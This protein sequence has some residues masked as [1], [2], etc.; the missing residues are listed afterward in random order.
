MAIPKPTKSSR[1]PRL[2]SGDHLTASEFLERYDEMPG[3]EKAVFIDGVV[4]VPS[5]AR[6]DLHGVQHKA[7]GT[8]WVYTGRT[9]PESRPAIVQR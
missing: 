8:G 9:R 7:L 3:L 2:E 4:Y 6:W 1:I 5:P